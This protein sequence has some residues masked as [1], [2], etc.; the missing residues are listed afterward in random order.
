MLKPIDTVYDGYRFRSR[1]EA[2]WA[3]FFK[4]LGIKYEY[5]KEGFDLD[6]QWYL[7]DFW[8][9]KQQCWVEIKGEEPTDRENEVAAK[10][11]HYSG[12]FVYIFFGQIEIPDGNSECAYLYD[13]L[14]NWDHFHIWCECPKCGELGIEF[15]GRAHRLPCNCFEEIK[16]GRGYNAYSERLIAAYNAAKCARFE[17]DEKD[18]Y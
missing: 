3:V 9:P 8:L 18:N 10:L 14:E 13:S 6:G 4:T 1:L 5:E 7:P 15:E 16:D 17:H 11:A 12:N 2:R